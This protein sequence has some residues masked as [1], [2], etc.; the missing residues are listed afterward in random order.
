MIQV[1]REGNFQVQL[2]CI[3]DREVKVL[4]NQA[5]GLVK[6]H[7]TCCGTED[8]TWEYEDAMREEYLHCF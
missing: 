5:I 4:Q 2:V 6:V 8:A 1:D 3:L 7:W